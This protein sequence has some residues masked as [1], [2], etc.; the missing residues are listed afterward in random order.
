MG[1]YTRWGRRDDSGCCPAGSVLGRGDCQR[2]LA[3]GPA[4]HNPLRR[5]EASGP[6]SSLLGVERLVC[7]LRGPTN[8]EQQSRPQSEQ[9]KACGQWHRCGR[10]D[11]KP[12]PGRLSGVIGRQAAERYEAVPAGARREVDESCPESA[13]VHS[14]RPPDDRPVIERYG[15]RRCAAD[16]DCIGAI[17]VEAET[18]GTDLE[19]EAG[20]QSAT[21]AG[22]QQ[23]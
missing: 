19:R 6:S 15:V 21:E 3:Y 18:R 20:G 14:K 11:P 4:V 1:T 10:G 8:R 12:S 9:G 5:T 22:R 23:R 17:G 2:L 7:P 13:V 16:S